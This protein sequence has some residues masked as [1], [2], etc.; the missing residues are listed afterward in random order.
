L[1]NLKTAP[2]SFLGVDSAYE[3]ADQ[4]ILGLPL[5]QTSC[6]RH[7]SRFAPNAI[8]LA[9]EVLETFSFKL[10]KDFDDL[11]ICDLGDLPLGAQ[12][13]EKA[14]DTIGN[15]VKKILQ[16]QKFLISLGGEHLITLPIISE[17]IKLHPDLAIIHFDAHLDL[18]EEY[19][20]RSKSHATVMNHVLPLLQKPGLAQ[21]GIRSADKE[22]FE[23][24]G[25][26]RSIFPATEE[27]ILK[28]LSQ[29]AGRPL[30]VSIDIDCLDPAFAPG[31]STPE[32]GGLT[33]NDFMEL[34]CLIPGKAMVGLDIVELCPPF[35]NS[36]ITATAA[37][38]I[39]RELA[40]LRSIQK[41]S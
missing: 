25:E 23:L 16:D 8:R 2:L 4:V 22:E 36:D 24:A 41:K 19:E 37:A 7:G 3:Q 39:V 11:K 26:I 17:L 9:S 28:A 13:V 31:A 29:L 1:N 38:K 30:Y 27:G 6:F 34:V 21:F 12:P 15:T 10:E 14:L 20:G 35:D 40:I 5:D 32:P 18:R 33:F